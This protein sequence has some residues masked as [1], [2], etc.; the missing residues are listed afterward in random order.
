MA[1]K[2]KSTKIFVLSNHNKNKWTLTPTRMF[3]LQAGLFYIIPKDEVA[4]ALRAIPRISLGEEVHF[5]GITGTPTQKK[6][7]RMALNYMVRHNNLTGSVSFGCKT[8]NAQA[9]SKLKKW[10][11]V[12]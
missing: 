12:Q 1:S 8:F 6:A 7:A 4:K 5:K 10:A 2:K 3:T 9:V 11:G